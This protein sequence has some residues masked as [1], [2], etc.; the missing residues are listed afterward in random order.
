MH[1]AK[2][3]TPGPLFGSIVMNKPEPIASLADTC[4][5]LERIAAQGDVVKS[6]DI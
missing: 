6:I 1:L 5:I 3:W 4:G 2:S